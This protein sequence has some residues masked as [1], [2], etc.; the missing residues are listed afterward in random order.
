MRLD[1]I[2][3]L[4]IDSLYT[5]LHDINTLISTEEQKSVD[6]KKDIDLLRK[7]IMVVNRNSE[8]IRKFSEEELESITDILI[9]YWDFSYDKEEVKNML[10][11]INL[12]L[13]GK[14][15]NN[16]MM[17]LSTEQRSF[18]NTYLNA[19][20]KCLEL[21]TN[22]Y[23]NRDNGDDSLRKIYSKKEDEILNLEILFEKIKDPNDTD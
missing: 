12:V 7:F 19:S 11:L 8:G 14:C 9:K 17:D 21:M 1:E 15:D 5:E 10:K 16:I 18:L 22:K 3:K 13:I 23:K 6:L 4:R 2:I 20:N